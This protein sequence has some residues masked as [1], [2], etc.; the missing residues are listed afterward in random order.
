MGVW[1]LKLTLPCEKRNQGRL[2]F[3][4]VPSQLLLPCT[5]CR[6]QALLQGIAGFVLRL[7]DKVSHSSPAALKSGTESSKCPYCKSMSRNTTATYLY[8]S[9][10]CQRKQH[11]EMQ[12]LLKQLTLGDMNL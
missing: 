11:N 5:V 10:H 9:V 2:E 3:G 8:A 4:L 6:L 7:L 12:S 1:G